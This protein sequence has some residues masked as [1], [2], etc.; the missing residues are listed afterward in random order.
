[1]DL[2]TTDRLIIEPLTTNDNTFI[3][4]LVN[5]KGWLEFIGSRNVNSEA[6]ATAYIQKIVDNS[7]VNYW[8]VR[9]R[10][11]VMP[12]GIITFIKRSYLSHHDIGAAFL[13]AYTN[14]G[15]AYEAT[16]AVLH[17]VIHAGEHSHILSITSPNNHS[18]I[19]LLKKLG[20]QFDKKIEV[21]NEKLKVYS[22]S[23]DKL[24]I[25][26]ITNSFFEV[27]NTK[28]KRQPKLNL[29]KNICITEIIIISKTA[30]THTVYDL[31]LF[32]ETRKM[33]LTDGTLTEFDEK[34]TYE[35]TRIIDNMAQRY[36]AYEKSGILTG[37]TFKQQGYKLFQFIKTDQFWKIASLIWEDKEN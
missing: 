8:V 1:M 17:N 25:N 5:T 4:E 10:E 33:K 28:N 24:M 26:E 32:I 19:K 15:Y 35:E 16:Q 6:E 11:N 34:E 13:P 18:A 23:T 3:H 31:D 22:A 27:F 21:E 30:V 2:L 14:C 29:L 37:K 12:V 36:S 9:I 7:D 20:L